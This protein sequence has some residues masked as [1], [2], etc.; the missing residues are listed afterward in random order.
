MASCLHCFGL[1]AKVKLKCKGHSSDG[2]QRDDH[3]VR[4]EPLPVE[5]D[6]LRSVLQLEILNDAEAQ[7]QPRRSRTMLRIIDAKAHHAI[8]VV[9][10]GPDACRCNSLQHMSSMLAT[11]E[12]FPAH[13]THHLISSSLPPTGYGVDP[14]TTQAGVYQGGHGQDSAP[15]QSQ[16]RVWST[17]GSSIIGTSGTPFE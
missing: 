2:E 13:V 8:T 15:K 14:I 1:M 6:A 5:T 4:D 11:Q 17:G 16:K 12:S 9:T 7:R 10:A 3:A